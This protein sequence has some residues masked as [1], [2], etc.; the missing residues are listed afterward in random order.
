MF[1]KIKNGVSS[2]YGKLHDFDRD[3][4]LK[5]FPLKLIWLIT[6]VVAIALAIYYNIKTIIQYQKYQV[7]TEI[8]E[9]YQENLDF[10]VITI[11]NVNPMGTNEANE[12]IQKYYADK[13][14]VSVSTSDELIHLWKS[15]QIGN[16]REDMA[17]IFY[18][19]YDPANQDLVGHFGLNTI[20]SCFMNEE[21]CELEHLFEL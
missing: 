20:V 12:F 18:K 14:N 7:T 8:R 17:Y 3:A 19:T 16:V 1:G 15:G 21:Q 13:Y 9:I 10:P 6:F 11:C 2:I 4:T 5:H